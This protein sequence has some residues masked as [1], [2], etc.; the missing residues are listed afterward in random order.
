M[1]KPIVTKSALGEIAGYVLP[2][3]CGVDK[4]IFPN[5]GLSDHVAVLS[6]SRSHTE[7][8]LASAPW[9]VGGL[10]TAPNRPL[11]WAAGFD[12]A[13]LVE[14]AKPW[15]DLG[16]RL[17]MA[18][19][20]DQSD[21]KVAKAQASSVLDQLHTVLEVLQVLRTITTEGYFEGPALVSHTLVEY[22]DVK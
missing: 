7:R 18:E 12:W 15:T 21:P 13:A 11:V 16:A 10:L 5:A 6:L 14:A 8:L 19:K 17:I 4:V 22:R 1:P 9:K 2:A 20:L 3:K